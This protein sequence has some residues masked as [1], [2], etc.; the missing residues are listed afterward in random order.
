MSNIQPGTGFLFQ[1]AGRGAALDIVKPWPAEFCPDGG[2]NLAIELYRPHPF[3]IS[4]VTAETGLGS[5]WFYNL[6]PD[7]GST[8]YVASGTVNGTACALGPTTCGTG[9]TNVYVQTYPDADIQIIAT[10]ST[11]ASSDSAAYLLI[12]QVD[13][14]H[15]TQFVKSDILRERFKL[16]QMDADYHYS[17][18]D[19]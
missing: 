9:L 14:Y 3:R 10:T 15:K 2:T 16:G 11:L 1:Q 17:Y 5:G 7:T 18:T 19:L 4:K 13:Q 6:N 12:G 8:F